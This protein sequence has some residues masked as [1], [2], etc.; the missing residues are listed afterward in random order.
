LR[1]DLPRAVNIAWGDFGGTPDGR[2]KVDR[3]I[4]GRHQYKRQDVRKY[5]KNSD[6]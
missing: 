4:N 1:Q 6:Y 2:A 3:H 5:G